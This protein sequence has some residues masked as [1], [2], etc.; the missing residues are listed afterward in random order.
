[1]MVKPSENLYLPK[2]RGEKD[3]G[4]EAL[5]P[6]RIR[7]RRVHAKFCVGHRG[8]SIQKFSF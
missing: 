1:M 5:P 8:R 6:A 2:G 4:R 3:Q 7:A